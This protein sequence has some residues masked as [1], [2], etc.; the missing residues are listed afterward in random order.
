M[1]I[2][3]L[4]TGAMLPALIRLRQEEPHAFPSAIRRMMNLMI[5][6][7]AP[8]AAVFICAPG[9][10]L[11]LLHYTGGYVSAVPP[12]LEISGSTLAIWFIT[13]AMGAAMVASDQQAQLSKGALGAVV[14]L[15]PA[16][17]ICTWAANRYLHN[18]AIGAVVADSLSEVYML[19][20]YLRM[21]PRGLFGKETLLYAVR[22]GFAAS[23]MGAA[24][25]LFSHHMGLLAMIP[26]ALVYAAL[27][28]GSRCV[29][30]HD[31]AVL[32]A[33]FTRRAETAA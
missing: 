6:C 16:S 3:T 10:L 4:V 14:T 29:T 33:A 20:Y 27:C 28:W 21:L 11:G 18:G 26:G 12:V 24:I 13:Q 22:V 15:I 5:L 8:M 23:C 25:A 17:L 1:F 30:R 19:F 32:R 7:A 31:V 9:R 2:P